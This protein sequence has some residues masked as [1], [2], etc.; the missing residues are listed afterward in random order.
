MVLQLSHQQL[1]LRVWN[2]LP[3]GA[4]KTLLLKNETPSLMLWKGLEQKHDEKVIFAGHI[5]AVK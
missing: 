3:E 2:S 4:P 5:S 1:S